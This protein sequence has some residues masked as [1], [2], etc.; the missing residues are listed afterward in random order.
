MKHA[1]RTSSAQPSAVTVLGRIH[2]NMLLS[3]AVRGEALKRL[4]VEH[5]VG[6]DQRYW[7]LAEALSALYPSHTDENRWIDGV[8]ASKKGLDF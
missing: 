7:R 3:A 6:R 4:L 1:I 8:L 5:G 2:Q